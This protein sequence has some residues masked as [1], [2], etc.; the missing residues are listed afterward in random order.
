VA[1][2]AKNN[3]PLLKQMNKAVGLYEKDAK[4]GGLKSAPGLAATI[5][6]SGKQR[7]LTIKPAI[8]R[9]RKSASWQAPICRCSKR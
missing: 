8:S 4:K 7:M 9:K 6:L 2:V 5:N 3:L 1:A